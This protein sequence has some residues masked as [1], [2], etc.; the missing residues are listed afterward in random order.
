[1]NGCIFYGNA[2]GGG[3]SGAHGLNV[4]GFV[5]T[6]LCPL[7]TGSTSGAFGIKT[8]AGTV[9]VVIVT[10]TSGSYATSLGGSEI[11]NASYVPFYSTTG[12]GGMRL[13]NGG[14]IN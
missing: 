11:T 7:A 10:A 1:V 14:L 2:T 4:A 5:A 6:V 3:I 12:G 9:S 8:N 13:I